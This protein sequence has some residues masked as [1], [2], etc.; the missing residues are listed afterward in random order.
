MTFG[1]SVC[2][3]LGIRGDGEADFMATHG[4]STTIILLIISAGLP[5]AVPVLRTDH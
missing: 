3:K 4:I 2:T 1:N 5:D